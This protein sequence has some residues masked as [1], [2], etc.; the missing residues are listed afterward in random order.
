[1][2]CQEHG[3]ASLVR[4][5]EDGAPPASKCRSCPTL[6]SP[7]SSTLGRAPGEDGHPRG[8]TKAFCHCWGKAAAKPRPIIRFQGTAGSNFTAP[9]QHRKSHRGFAFPFF[10]PSMPLLTAEGSA[11]RSPLATQKCPREGGTNLIFLPLSTCPV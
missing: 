3:G 9:P 6:S 5:A 4:G 8:S 7:S 1:M 2:S 11:A 10:S